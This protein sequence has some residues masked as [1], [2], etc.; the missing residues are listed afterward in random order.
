MCPKRCQ[1]ESILFVWRVLLYT[2][3]SRRVVPSFTSIALRLRLWAGGV[4]GRARWFLSRG[5]TVGMIPGW[6]GRIILFGRAT[7]LRGR[8]FGRVE[9]ER[10]VLYDG[11]GLFTA[12]ADMCRLSQQ[13]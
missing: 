12:I 5:R 3:L 2:R 7:R 4:G 10:G 6:C 8:R 1:T 11:G 13:S 9:R